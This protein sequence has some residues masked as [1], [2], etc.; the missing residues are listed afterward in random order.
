MFL[1]DDGHEEP[2]PSAADK[3]SEIAGSEGGNENSNSQNSDVKP[4]LQ[5]SVNAVIFLK[6]ESE[7]HM[8]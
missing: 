5:F 2:E 6:F 4:Q 1:L 7:S 3:Q 8:I